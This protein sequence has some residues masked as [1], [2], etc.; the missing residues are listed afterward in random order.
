[1]SNL[2]TQCREAVIESLQGDTRF[3]D[4]A[5]WYEHKDGLRQ[6]YQIDP[7]HCPYVA[8]YPQ[9][10]DQD[11]PTNAMK[12]R[13]Y[14]LRVE[15]GHA[16]QNA[17]PAEQFAWDFLDWVSERK[18]DHLGMGD[19]GLS[20]IQVDGAPVRMLPRQEAPKIIWVARFSLTFT[21]RISL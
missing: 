8:V 19:T 11:E 17:E 12:R 5:T 6:R 13:P 18:D 1:M 15:C 16:G 20:G 4:I 14:G 21:W 9:E 3:G 10:V 2:F 7:A